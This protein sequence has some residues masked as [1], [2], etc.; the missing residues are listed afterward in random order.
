MWKRKRSRWLLLVAVVLIVVVVLAFIIFSGSPSSEEAL[1]GVAVGDEFIYDIKTAWSSND[2]NA[3]LN[4]YYVQLNTTEWY[5]ITITDVNGSTVSLSTVWR[6]TNGTEVE[7]TSTLN[8]KTGTA[9]PYNAFWGVYVANLEVNDRIRPS[10]A[11][12]AVV[13][14]TTTRDYVSGTREINVVSLSEEYYDADD[15]TY[16][17]TLTEHMNIKFDKQK[18]MLV[19]FH[20]ISIYT[21]P[22]QTYTVSWILEETN[23]W[24]V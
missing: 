15:P 18:G 3:I 24:D 11:T 19:E 1:P 7:G 9:Y 20:D 10:G 5:K 14:D 2:P 12:Q 17:T 21:K 6:F 8:V 16:S 13:N 4:E 23:V 22:S